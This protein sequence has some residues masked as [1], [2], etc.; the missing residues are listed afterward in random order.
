MEVTDGQCRSAL[1][2]LS[3]RRVGVGEN[4]AREKVGQVGPCTGA[5]HE[6]LR[7]ATGDTPVDASQPDRVE[8]LAEVELRDGIGG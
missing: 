5:S 2:S 8:R 3:D 6:P 4:R 1:A 7:R